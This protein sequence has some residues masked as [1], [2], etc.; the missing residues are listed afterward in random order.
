MHICWP[1]AS[2]LASLMFH[3]AAK[4]EGPSVGLLAGVGAV[5]LAA[6]AAISSRTGNKAAA[7]APKPNQIKAKIKVSPSA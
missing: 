6:A 1:Y 3:A 4:G 2:N 5:V 7:K